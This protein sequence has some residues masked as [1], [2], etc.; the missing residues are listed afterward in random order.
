MIC[1]QFIEARRGWG[2]TGRKAAMGLAMVSS[3]ASA[4]AAEVFR[5]DFNG[6]TAPAA[7]FNGKQYESGLAV[8]YGGTLASWDKSGG[9]VVHAVNLTTTPP[10]AQRDFAVMIWQDNVITLNSPIV[11][12]NQSGAKYR[13]DFLASPAV[14]QAPSQVTAPE[15]GVLVEVLRADDTVL[16]SQAY[17]PGA[18]A[19]VLDMKPGSFE[20]V[21]DGSGDVRLRVGP[22]NFGSGHFGGAIDDLKLSGAQALFSADF[23]DFTAPPNQFNGLQYQTGL[24]V[25]YGG[26]LGAWSKSGGGVVHAVNRIAPPPPPAAD[27]AVMLWQDNVIELR[28]PIAGSN[29]VGQ[30][31]EV[32]FDASPAVYQA[33]SQVT[34]LDDGVFVEVLRGDNTVLARHEYR[35]GDWAGTI[36]LN[37]VAFQYTGDGSGDIRLKVGP[38]NFGSGHFGGAVDNLVLTTAALV[39]DYNGN[40]IYDAADI[41]TLSSAVRSGPFEARFDLNSDGKLTQGDRLVWINEKARTYVGDTN[42]DGLFNSTDFVMAFQAGQYEDAV[43]GNSTW[44]TGDWDGNANFDSADFVAAF[45]QGGY[46]AGPRTAVAA[47][48]EPSALVLW[49]LCLVGLASR[50]VRRG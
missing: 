1:T 2:R 15:D 50:R 32:A 43:P 7:N 33:P 45:Q 35:P 9:G 10:P 26:D 25:A 48:P 34:T 31:Y 29:Q 28:D 23:N 42:L 4:Q 3:L 27:Y 38:S 20:Y 44:G 22:S 39:G 30:S 13:L 11:G 16:A 47:V 40:G 19:G 14:Y 17:Q 36:D 18:W 5:E 24:E 6:F 37:R 12:S 41:D 21:G 49:G 8:A 46:E